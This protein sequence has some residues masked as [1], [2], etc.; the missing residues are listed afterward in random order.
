MLLIR[1]ARL[2]DI[3][4]LCGMSTA[5]GP[6]MTSMPA[7]REMW[8]IRLK[9]S[10]QCFALSEVEG[11]G[12]YFL[13]LED[14]ANGKLVGSTAIYTGIGLKHPFYSYKCSTLVNYSATLDRTV[15]QKVLHLVND[16]TG[17]TEL[18]S[19]FLAP[20]YRKDNNGA[21]LSRCR[22]LL[23][24]R[25]RERFADI[26]IAE[27]RGWQDENGHSPFWRHL[28]K[29]FFGIGFD[30]ADYMNA[31]TGT[32]FISDL[33]PRYPIYVDLLNRK[34]REVVGKPHQDSARALALLHKEGFYFADYVDIFDG[35]PTVQ[36]RR[37][38]IR[39]V[40]N[41]TT[42]IVARIVENGA[43]GSHPSY[44]VANDR[45]TDYR[46]IK[47]PLEF[48]ADGISIDST[49]A[50]ALMLRPGDPVSILPVHGSS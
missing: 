41:T 18:G 11:G 4:C 36:C 45:L 17:A 34:A 40:R 3:D 10:E 48:V 19:L 5:T 37:D 9:R 15:T 8:E 29:K 6:G 12:V 21:F 32:Q 16:Y 28:G 2:D 20:E 26:V 46:V 44:I 24:A 14:G 33:M 43:T 30:N 13:V 7:N 39:S 31:V 25:Y 50:S 1:P 49:A 42:P 23:L 38:E 47:T 22:Y 27:L 35:G